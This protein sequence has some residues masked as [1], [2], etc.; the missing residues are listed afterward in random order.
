MLVFFFFIIWNSDERIHCLTS[1]ENYGPKY[2]LK[3]KGQRVFSN[4][5]TI[6]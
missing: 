5:E 6:K 4:K 2:E 1:K 3:T